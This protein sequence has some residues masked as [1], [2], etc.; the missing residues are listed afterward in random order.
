[1]FFHL[2]RWFQK[3]FNFFRKIFFGTPFEIFFFSRAKI[4]YFGTLYGLLLHLDPKMPFGS[5]YQGGAPGAPPIQSSN[6]WSPSK[7]GLSEQF[8]GGTFCVF[9]VTLLFIGFGYLCSRLRLYDDD[10]VGR[11]NLE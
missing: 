5:S 4:L 8:F 9:S 6:S 1:M 2:L 7:V 10:I 11:W 3:I